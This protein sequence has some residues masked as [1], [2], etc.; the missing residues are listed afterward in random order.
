M[1]R[2]IFHYSASPSPWKNQGPV[3]GPQRCDLKGA[4]P[5]GTT[6]FLEIFK[7]FT[8]FSIFSPWSLHSPGRFSEHKFAAF[9]GPCQQN[10]FGFPPFAPNM[11]TL[12]AKQ[13]S[14]HIT[15]FTLYMIYVSL[16]CS[17]DNTAAAIDRAKKK[18]TCAKL[19]PLQIDV[20]T[21]Q[22]LHSLPNAA[23]TQYRITD[24][25]SDDP[26]HERPTCP[27]SFVR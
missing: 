1:W 12:H 17:G 20:A 22:S 18:K 6:K 11:R 25:I 27:V 7:R 4:T 13:H 8:R 16:H 15:C 19:V 3:T 14:R 5:Q 24:A 2:E 26:E 9:R 10:P 21:S 23:K